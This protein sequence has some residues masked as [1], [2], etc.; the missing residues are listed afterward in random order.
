S[1]LPENLEAFQAA[2]VALAERSLREE[3][4]VRE[5]T[6]DAEVVF[7]E[8]SFDVVDE[9]LKLQPFGVGNPSPLL[10]AR[11]V[12]VD[13]V[14]SLSQGHLRLRFRQGDHVLQGV[15]WRF[16]GH[17]LLA[18]GKSVSI[19]FHAEINV[20]RGVSSIQLNLREVWEGE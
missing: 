12:L 6:A 16:R 10:V 9:L 4:L 14:Q 5:R 15:A 3:Q 19:A 20:Y 2:F 13:S 11:N 7:G 18:K 1:V 17:P 8:L